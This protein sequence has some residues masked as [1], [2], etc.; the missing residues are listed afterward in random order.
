MTTMLLC[1]SH[2]PL[3]SCFAKEPD[4]W[5]ELQGAYGERAAAVAEFDPEIVITF[6]SD[7]YNG[8]FLKLMPPFCIGLSAHAVGDIGGTAGRLNV[9]EQTARELIAFLR[10]HDVDPA[11][12]TDMTLDH[13]FSQ[14]IDT[15]CGGLTGYP[16]VPIFINCISEPF[17]PFRRSRLMGSAVGK[18]AADTGKRVLLLGSG[19]MSHHPR[20]YY[21]ELGDGPPEVTAWQLSGGEDAGSLSSGEW[22]DRLEEMHHEGAAMI[23]RGE[24]TA[25]DMCLNAEAD[26]RFLDVLLGQTLS[27]F[28]GWD[29]HE[30]VRDAGIGSMELHTW[31]AASAAHEAAGGGKP[32]LDFYAIT[33]ELGIATGIVHG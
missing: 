15:L 30:V 27:E 20:R 26:Q 19:G 7:H 23:V 14:S 21:P 1:A 18:F 28:D 11:S 3:M 12:S 33:P 17:V 16:T 24:R 5:E 13:A 10:E 29:P 25:A 6:G 2:S 31:I 8:F 32:E 22:L 9:P 4:A